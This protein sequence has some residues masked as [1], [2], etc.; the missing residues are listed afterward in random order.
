[1]ENEINLFQ[2]IVRDAPDIASAHNNMGVAYYRQGQMD[3]AIKEYLIVE[4]QS[5]RS[6]GS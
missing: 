2:K 5:E 4:T 1:M 3:K 6:G